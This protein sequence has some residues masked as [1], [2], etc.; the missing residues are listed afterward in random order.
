[1]SCSRLSHVRKRSVSR[2]VQAPGCRNA[3]RGRL[4]ACQRGGRNLT[5]P[6]ANVSK[7][8][9]SLQA[10]S[11]FKTT[12]A[13]AAV[14]ST[15]PRAVRVKSRFQYLLPSGFLGLAGL[16]DLARFGGRRFGGRRLGGA[17]LQ[18]LGGFRSGA[19]ACGGVVRGARALVPIRGEEV[20][21]GLVCVRARRCH[22]LS[23]FLLTS[24][25]R[26][27]PSTIRITSSCGRRSL[28]LY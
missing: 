10:G 19:H 13:L 3:R 7:A 16:V 6:S 20:I 12:T 26:P 23:H 21:T 11:L 24:S 28:P 25:A 27:P 1:M 5:I 4:N 14:P 8:M 9:R 17:P 15:S 18:R 2:S 22:R